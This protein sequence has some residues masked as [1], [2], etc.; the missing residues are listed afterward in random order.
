MADFVL[1]RLHEEV[2]FVAQ[3]KALTQAKK[4]KEFLGLS[5]FSSNAINGY[6]VLRGHLKS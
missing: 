1:N 5:I 2:Q 4:I 6:F 3:N